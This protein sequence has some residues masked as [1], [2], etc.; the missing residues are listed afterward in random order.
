MS[1]S[2]KRQGG[3]ANSTFF[4]TTYM[5]SGKVYRWFKVKNVCEKFWFLQFQRKASINAKIVDSIE[6]HKA[7][8]RLSYIR[9]DYKTY[10]YKTYII[11]NK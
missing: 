3:R 8:S 4:V 10:N 7:P 2:H 6:W 5:T 9:Y 11:Q 1:V